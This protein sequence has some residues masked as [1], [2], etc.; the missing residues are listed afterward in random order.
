MNLR[1]Y[2]R[3]SRHDREAVS[4]FDF[5]SGAL[6]KYE[7]VVKQAFMSGIQSVAEQMQQ[8]IREQLNEFWEGT[9]SDPWDYPFKR[10]GD[11]QNAIKILHSNTGDASALYIDNEEAPYWR[12]LEYGT[13]KMEPRPFWRRSLATCHPRMKAVMWQEVHRFM[14]SGYRMA[15]KPNVSAPPSSGGQARS[16]S[17]RKR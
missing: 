14:N 3:V 11:L 13:R 17:Y 9:P 7:E 1:S 16:K 5:P 2:H 15:P 12:Y 10:T 6:D 4:F 8:Y